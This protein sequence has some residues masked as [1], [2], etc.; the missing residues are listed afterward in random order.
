MA[1]VVNQLL[2]KLTPLSSTVIDH[3]T[4]SNENHTVAYFY[5]IR[6]A[7]HTKNADPEEILRA[8]LKQLVILLP[9]QCSAPV[10]AKYETEK[11]S[12]GDHGSIRRLTFEECA[13]FILELGTSHP[14]TIVI[15]AL[16]ECRE[17]A[18][19]SSQSSHTDRQDLLNRLQGMIA[20]KPGNFKVFLSSRD[21]DD[22]RD[23]LQSYPNITINASKNGKDIQ[24]YIESEVD[25][26]I[27]K[28]SYLRNDENLRAE[29]IT[30]IGDRA[31][32][33]FVFMTYLAPIC[34]I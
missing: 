5:C 9:I 21:D 33:M 26:L 31:D 18:P 3:L 14:I 2:R 20:A 6:D 8:I 34:L 7:Q 16:D 24:R 25:K 30:A 11:K 22:I 29:I 15:D 12:G 13:N 19:R 23:H 10:K 32:G 27:A 1:S 28:R 4:S 17:I